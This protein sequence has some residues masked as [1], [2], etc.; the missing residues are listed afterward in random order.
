MVST[1][2]RTERGRFVV[3][4]DRLWRLQSKGG[5]GVSRAPAPL[6]AEVLM[7]IHE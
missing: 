6:L 3:D 5:V 2:T 7:V 1:S 4:L